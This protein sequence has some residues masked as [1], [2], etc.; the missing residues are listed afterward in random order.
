MPSEWVRIYIK[1]VTTGM[2][3]AALLIALAALLLK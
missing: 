1:G 2:A 3:V